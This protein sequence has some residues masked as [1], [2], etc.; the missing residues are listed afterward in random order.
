MGD[1]YL[2]RG[3]AEKAVGGPSDL[4]EHFK[5]PNSTGIDMDKLEMVLGDTDGD[6][7]KQ[8]GMSFN[9]DFFD[10][11]WFNKPVRGAPMPPISWT[12]MDRSG[13]L[14]DARK[15]LRKYIWITGTKNQAVPEIVITE[16]ALGMTGLIEQGRRFASLS[17][18]INPATSRHFDRRR[19][20]KIGEPARG[21][22]RGAFKWYT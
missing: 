3:D 13:V 14:T 2:T 7:R 17:T 22:H 18:Q 8:I 15:I 16:S 1:H 5:V 4:R 20:R 11:L 10:A 21:S 19:S 12:D 6:I 9:L